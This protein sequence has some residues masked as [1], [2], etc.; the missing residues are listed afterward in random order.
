MACNRIK[1]EGAVAWSGASFSFQRR[2]GRQEVGLLV[3]GVYVDKIG[4]EIGDKEILLS[5]VED[6]FV[7]VGSLLTVGDWSGAREGVGEYL[8]G[9]DVAGRGY[10]VGLERASGTTQREGS[11]ACKTRLM[12]GD[13]P[14][15]KLQDTKKY[16]R[17]SY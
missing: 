10:V 17:I 16:A 8:R 15:W 11:V 4:S 13:L 9:S 12:D 7:R 3:D 1:R 6:C 14:V 5:G 2:E